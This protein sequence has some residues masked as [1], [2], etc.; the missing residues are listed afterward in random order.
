MQVRN[1]VMD[2]S[3]QNN[4]SSNLGNKLNCSPSLSKSSK[5]IQNMPIPVDPLYN[6]KFE[7]KES[8][9]SDQRPAYFLDKS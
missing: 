6:E 2:V 9:T 3:T 5:S 8:M 4:R 1:T 7:V